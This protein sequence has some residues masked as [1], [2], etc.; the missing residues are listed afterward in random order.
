ML[1]ACS[2][3]EDHQS[4]GLLSTNAAAR[5]DPTNTGTIRTAFE[6]EVNRRFARLISEIRKKLTV[7]FLE[8]QLVVNRDRY[9]FPRSQAKV[10][11]FMSWLRG[12][13][14]D[15][16]VGRGSSPTAGVEWA[17][18]YVQ[19]AYRRGIVQAYGELR[20]AGVT[21]PSLDSAFLRPIHAARLASVYS[22]DFAQLTGITGEMSRQIGEVLAE[23][24]ADGRGVRHIAR[25]IEDRVEKVGRTRARTLA[26]TEVIRSHA[27]A[28]I[29]A[30]REA[31]MEGVRIRAEFSTSRDDKVCPECAAL[32]GRVF[33]MDEIEG[34]IPIHPN[35]RCGI[36][37]VVAEGPN[38]AEADAAEARFLAD[39]G[40]V[41]EV[42]QPT[43]DVPLTERKYSEDLPRIPMNKFTEDLASLRPDEQEMLDRV[44]VN[45]ARI[46][47]TAKMR[48]LTGG[49][50]KAG[51]LTEFVVEG[52]NDFVVSRKFSYDAGGVPRAVDHS[53]FRVPPKLRGKGAKEFLDDTVSSYA[54]MG[55]R[56]IDVEANIDVGGYAWL[57]Y[58]FK[59]NRGQFNIQSLLSRAEGL[60]VPDAKFK[61]IARMIRERRF[62]AL[63]D[64]DEVVTLDGKKM[65]IGK[66]LFLRSYWEG[67]LDLT[68]ADA[69][70]RFHAYVRKA[71]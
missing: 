56:K 32:E 31:G 22:R 15:I 70:A 42:A 7:G 12:T 40:D 37:P 67:S 49:R 64:M 29:G 50:E 19:S 66:H 54:Q 68:D 18:T 53:L 30:Y 2:C 41:A 43:D 3:G 24:M 60:D 59:P 44:R 61:L 57:R 58:G 63:A 35:C 34:M 71:R 36:I 25:Q 20:G 69:M 39:T 6:A 5:R 28:S 4:H 48:I 55:F 23:G 26:R 46:D 51:R 11:S 62:N 16:I 14:M 1:A 10:D 17:N 45:L 38:Q 8:P 33:S 47:P 65:S 27:D 13:N 52:K 9:T 21:P